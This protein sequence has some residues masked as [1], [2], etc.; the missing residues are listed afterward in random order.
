M[1]NCVQFSSLMACGLNYCMLLFQFGLWP[2]TLAP[3]ERNFPLILD[4]L[5]CWHAEAVRSAFELGE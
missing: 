3:L 2:W 5:M 4:V 1:A